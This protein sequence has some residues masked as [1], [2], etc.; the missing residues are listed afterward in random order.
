[1]PDTPPGVVES[2]P[3]RMRE[4]DLRYDMCGDP[5]VVVMMARGGGGMVKNVRRPARSSKTTSV[6]AP[7]PDFLA[8]RANVTKI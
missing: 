2:E 8:L 3:R 4:N 5:K 1:V 7:T 6:L